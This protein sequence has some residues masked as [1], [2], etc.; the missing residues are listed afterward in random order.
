MWLKQPLTSEKEIGLRHDVVDAFVQDP[1]LRE[2]LRDQ[3]LR[4]RSG[5][6]RLSKLNSLSFVSCGLYELPADQ[7]GQQEASRTE[8]M[9]QRKRWIVKLVQEATYTG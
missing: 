7:I 8:F 3:H 6:A 2:K 9:A 1:E 4:G 5:Q